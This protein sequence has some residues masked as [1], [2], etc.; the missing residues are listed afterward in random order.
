MLNRI[1]IFKKVNV[2]YKEEGE[3]FPAAV[4]NSSE[5]A[6]NFVRQFYKSDISLYETCFV[7]FLDKHNN[8]LA[9]HK[10][11]LGSRYLHILDLNLVV[12][13]AIN[14]SAAQIVLVHNHPTFFR[15]EARPSDGDIELTTDLKKI[16]DGAGIIF[17]D[18]IILYLNS[19]Y[20]FYDER[21]S[22]LKIN[23]LNEKRIKRIITKEKEPRIKLCKEIKYKIVDR[24][25]NFPVV[26]IENCEDAIDFVRKRFSNE[27]SKKE[28]YFI[29]CLDEK[30][31]TM[32]YI[33]VDKHL[34]SGLYSDSLK[35]A[36]FI[37]ELLVSQFYL[38]HSYPINGEAKPVEIDVDFVENLNY[39]LELMDYFIN[40]YIILTKEN[41]LSFDK[42][43]LFY[44][45]YEIL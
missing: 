6:A 16:L 43:D 20:S 33:K 36:R 19:Y 21:G 39:R 1:Q 41:Y 17:R 45:G 22:F 26:K 9:Y 12:K 38:I 11:S 35:I 3:H 31:C 2:S 37:H 28:F 7:L 13:L 10:A 18:H 23:N 34:K 42:E 27:I 4:I 32:A 8:T 24:D 29:L 40:D 14:L 44:K 15:E 30:K 25:N 5:D